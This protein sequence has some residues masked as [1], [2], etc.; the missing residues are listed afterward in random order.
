MK[1]ARESAMKN[2]HDPNV[3]I[4]AVLDITEDGSP[5]HVLIRRR[6]EGSSYKGTYTGEIYQVQ[7]IAIGV[8]KTGVILAGEKEGDWLIGFGIEREWLLAIAWCCLAEVVRG[9]LRQILRSFQ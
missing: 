3:Q 5:R 6:D 2:I 4:L 8:T 7:A 9:W 1:T